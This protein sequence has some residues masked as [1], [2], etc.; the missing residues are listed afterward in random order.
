MDQQ[1]MPAATEQTTRLPQ[2]AGKPAT[3]PWKAQAWSWL[4]KRPAKPLPAAF[5]EL[6]ATAAA[7]HGQP[8]A[9]RPYA[10]AYTAPLPALDH[11]KEEDD[12]TGSLF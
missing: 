5:D 10:R 3:K 12:G 9:Q 8:G 2:N 6:Q 7:N 4:A 11:E 1:A